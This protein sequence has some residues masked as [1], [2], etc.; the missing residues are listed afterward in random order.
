MNIGNRVKINTKHLGPFING[1]KVKWTGSTGEKEGEV[2][3]VHLD[4]AWV[5]FKP[6]NICHSINIDQLE[7]F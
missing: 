2:M 6:T 7:V 3:C 5:K 1:C 4:Q